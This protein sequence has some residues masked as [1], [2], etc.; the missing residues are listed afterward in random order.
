M[1]INLSGEWIGHYPSFS[2]TVRIE[3]DGSS[4]RA[5]KIT[6]DDS[7]VPVGEVTFVYDFST[8]KGSG[9]VATQE[10][11]KSSWVTGSL[12]I[13]NDDLFIFRWEGIVDVEFRRDK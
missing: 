2:Q 11:R 13:I 7:F 10:F 8:R 6:S 4:I 1:N 12:R 5:I 9:R 3:Q